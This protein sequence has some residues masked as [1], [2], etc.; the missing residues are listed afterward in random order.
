MCL[1]SLVRIFSSIF[2]SHISGNFLHFTHM[3]ISYFYSF[4]KVVLPML[5]E[6]ALQLVF[7]WW[8]QLHNKLEEIYNVSGLVDSISVDEYYSMKSAHWF[9]VV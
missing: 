5:Q 9:I 3:R 7:V 8:L 6:K 4:Q 1:F 2:A